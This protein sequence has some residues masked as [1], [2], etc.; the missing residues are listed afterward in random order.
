V[1]RSILNDAI[2]PDDFHGCVYYSQ[3]AEQDQSQAFADQLVA[4]ASA[5]TPQAV[6]PMDRDAA[7]AISRAYM[8]G[9][10]AQHGIADANMIKPGI[11]EATRVL[12]RRTPRLLIVRDTGAPEVAHLLLLAAEKKVSVRVDPGLP[13]HAVSLIR[14]ALDA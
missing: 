13:Y 11:G 8:Q 9:A 12:L 5:L 7:A 1:S 3:F 4:R 2:G 14:S 10:M 6:A